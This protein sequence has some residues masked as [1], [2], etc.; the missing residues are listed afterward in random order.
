[1][2]AKLKSI[3]KQIPWS[4][5]LKALS[6]GVAWVALPYPLFFVAALTLYFVPV[7]DS[8]RFLFP[9]AVAVALGWFLP[10]NIF[11]FLLLAVIFFVMRGVRDLVFVDRVQAYQILLLLFLVACASVFFGSVH[12]VQGSALL[13]SALMAFVV[14]RLVRG[15]F[16]YA[17]AH[18]GIMSRYERVA[19]IVPLLLSFFLFELTLVILALPLNSLSQ[20]ALF[21]LGAA[22]GTDAAFD[23]VR[24]VLHEKRVVAA[25]SIFVIAA[26]LILASNQWGL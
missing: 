22:V 8:R 4:L 6:F 18:G 24:G 19:D 23:Y 10:E 25:A 15:F 12:R 2:A 20:L 13:L 5:A 9:F 3:S 16:E 14:W 17:L 1:M 21:F 11:S 7:F 26:F